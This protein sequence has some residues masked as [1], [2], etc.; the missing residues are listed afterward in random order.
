MSLRYAYL[1][2]ESLQPMSDPSELYEIAVHILV[3]TGAIE[4]CPEHDHIMLDQGDDEAESHAYALGMN[5]VKSGEV[6]CT[7]EEMKTAIQSA[8]RDA[9]WDCPECEREKHR[10]D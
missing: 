3:E 2:M 8:Y 4:A 10:S 9:A 1:G 7:F 6:R 5:K